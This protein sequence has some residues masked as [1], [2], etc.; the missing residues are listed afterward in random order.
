VTKVS[1][2]FTLGKKEERPLSESWRVQTAEDRRRVVETICQRSV[3]E[4]RSIASLVVEY[5]ISTATYQNWK[6]AMGFGAP[7]VP[8]FRPVEV[9]ELVPT[10]ASATT[11]TLTLVTASGHRIEGLSLEQAAQLVRSLEC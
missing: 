6:R 2:G 1:A 9:K 7:G 10:F 3:E 11:A 4:Q 5:G 8:S